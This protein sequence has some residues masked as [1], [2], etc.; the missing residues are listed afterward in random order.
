MKLIVSLLSPEALSLYVASDRI[1]VVKSVGWRNKPVDFFQID[2]NVQPTDGW[3]GLVQVIDQLSKTMNVGNL[4]IVLSD[5]FARHSS[6]PWRSDLLG[7]GEELAIA[8]LNFDETYGTHESAEWHFGFSAAPPGQSRLSVAIPK[9]LFTLLTTNFGLSHCKVTSIQTA[10]SATLFTHR[11]LLNTRGWIVNLEGDRLTLGSWDANAWIWIHSAQADIHSTSGLLERIGQELRLSCTILN[12]NQ[13]V[14][15]FLH[16]PAF[17]H[18]QF[19]TLSGTTL[20]P[21]KTKRETA[22]AKYAF[23]LMGAHA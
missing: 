10:F 12:V 14:P 13:P 6:F 8:K 15:I 11:K 23:A 9:S 2:A 21:L 5:K 3:Q 17:E 22:H 4:R 20:I 7:S 16:A 1:Q 18:L 19:G